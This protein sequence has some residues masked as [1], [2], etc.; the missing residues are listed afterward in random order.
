M[1]TGMQF[2]A[3]LSAWAKKASGKLDALARQAS[4]EVSFRVVQATPVD[5]GFLRSSWQPAIGAPKAAQGAAGGQAKAIKAGDIYW[6]TNNARYAKFVEYGTTRMSGRFFTTDTA[7][8]WQSIVNKIA[9]E[10]ATK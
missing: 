2:N 5:T 9:M 3:D 8:Q 1:K 7:S 4:Q 6:M 10:L